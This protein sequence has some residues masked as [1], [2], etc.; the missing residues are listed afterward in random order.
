MKLKMICPTETVENAKKAREKLVYL[1]TECQKHGKI[2]AR[3]MMAEMTTRFF[4]CFGLGF[5]AYCGFSLYGASPVISII[6]AA[7][8]VIAGVILSFRLPFLCSTGSIM[9][10]ARLMDTFRTV[11]AIIVSLNTISTILSE[12]PAL[13]SSENGESAQI[14][15]NEN[16][17]IAIE[18]SN[19]RY[20]FPMASRYTDFSDEYMG[21]A[22][23]SFQA[24]DS[25]IKEVTLISLSK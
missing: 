4:V 8:I 13:I 6:M 22:T 21:M 1:M 14:L 3:W 10:H 15:E 12:N 16:G 25:L 7:A 17:D 19:H 11:N 23:M 9:K 20:V 18:T 24:A 5:C 2:E